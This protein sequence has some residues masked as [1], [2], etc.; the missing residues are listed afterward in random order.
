MALG[1]SCP[2]PKNGELA[3]R[4]RRHHRLWLPAF[5]LLIGTVSTNCA[6][7]QQSPAD[8]QRPK[9]ETDVRNVQ[10]AKQ[11]NTQCVEPAPLVSLED[12]EG[13]M[14]KTVG[15][16]RAL[17]KPKINSFSCCRIH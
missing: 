16:S 7:P 9:I 13:P 2:A 10:T 17:S 12:Y 6:F 1:D 14:K 8:V 5:A 4:Y 3:L 15:F 11:A